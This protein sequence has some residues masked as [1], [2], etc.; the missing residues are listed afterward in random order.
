MCKNSTFTIQSQAKSGRGRQRKA[1]AGKAL[2]VQEYRVSEDR[3]DYI[4]RLCLKTE[5]D[6][7]KQE[8]CKK[9]KDRRVK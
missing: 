3:Q 7:T 9:K 2:G 4:E 5:Q 8:M 1:E 6:K